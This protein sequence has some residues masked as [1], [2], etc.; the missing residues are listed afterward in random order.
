MRRRN[1]KS[2]LVALILGIVL[3]GIGYAYLTTNLKIKGTTNIGN[4]KWD[5]HFE[6]AE[7]EDKSDTVS[8]ESNSNSNLAQG[9]PNIT[10]E[11]DTELEWQVV[12][13]QPGDYYY[14]TSDIV[15]AGDIDAEL[16]Y[17][18]SFITF[19]L[20]NNEEVKVALVNVNG[21]LEPFKVYFNGNPSHVNA[22]ESIKIIVGAEIDEDITTEQW[23]NIKG[24]T[25]KM[26]LDLKYVQGESSPRVTE[27]NP[28]I[29]F[30]NAMVTGSSSTITVPNNSNSNTIPA[31]SIINKGYSDPSIGFDPE[32]TEHTIDYSLIFNQPGDYYEFSVDLVSEIDSYSTTF[33][34][35]YKMTIN[36]NAIY[37]ISDLN[38]VPEYFN[39]QV[40]TDDRVNSRSYTFI[41]RTQS[42]KISVRIE[43]KD[44]LT[45]EQLAEIQGK[46]VNIKYNLK[47][48]K[49]YGVL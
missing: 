28:R 38:N 39:Y 6:N 30:E 12:L 43:L 34:E 25:V 17:E 5:V 24:K 47:Y 10:G 16:D 42:R 3:M 11:N 13:N 7:V 1:N 48:H 37:D 46:V 33:D 20:D 36:N 49:Y 18:N 27:T 29:R 22:G 41:N 40:T 19:Q 8:F 35:S 45:P 2:K 26:K 32:Y 14:V 4:N 23:N 9:L 31:P 21:E 44:N 15:N